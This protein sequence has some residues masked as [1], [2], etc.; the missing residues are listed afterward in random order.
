MKLEDLAEEDQ[1]L[2]KQ[3]M[4]NGNDQTRQTDFGYT[5]QYLRR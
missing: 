2:V 4:D 1:K 3:A 5:T